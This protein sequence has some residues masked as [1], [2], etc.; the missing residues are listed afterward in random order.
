MKSIK[1]FLLPL[2]SAVVGWLDQR[3]FNYGTWGGWILEAAHTGV[4]GFADT[5][6]SISAS[7]P[8][9]YNAT[10]YG[11]TTGLAWT[12]IGSVESF[13][14]I[15]EERSSTDFRPISGAVTTVK[16]A[17]KYGGGDMVMADIPADTGQ[18]ICKAA[19][20]SENH[21]SMKVTYADGEIHYL[22]VLLSSWIMVQQQEGAIMKRTCNVQVQ[23]DPVVVAAS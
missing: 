17:S 18:V 1:R 19:V 12:V 4:A 23:R 9:T 7:L 8:A 20:A 11:T 10:G 6:Y 3:L 22:D 14:T 21:Y 16:G 13:P 15:G 5:T 2:F